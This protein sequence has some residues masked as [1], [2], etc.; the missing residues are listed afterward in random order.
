MSSGGPR[1]RRALGVA[2]ALSLVYGGSAVAQESDPVDSQTND[3]TAPADPG[4]SPAPDSG[5]SEGTPGSQ[6]HDH[7]HIPPKASKGSGYGGRSTGPSPL[8]LL[9]ADPANPVPAPPTSETLPDEVDIDLPYQRQ[10]VCDP[11]DKP[12]LEAFGTLIGQHYD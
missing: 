6:D 12:G 4:G 7:D 9:P 1:L 10:V 11:T 3:S 2:M 8:P 5:T